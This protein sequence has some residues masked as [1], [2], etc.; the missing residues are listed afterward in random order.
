MHCEIIIKTKLKSD[1]RVG[2]AS[3]IGL[4][5]SDPSNLNSRRFHFERQRLIVFIFKGFPLPIED[6]LPILPVLTSQG[7]M[8]T[9]EDH[10][11]EAKIY[12]KVLVMVVMETD[13]RL[14]WPH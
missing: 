7:V 1:L 12:V 13:W 5:S 14:P 6:I 4:T 2:G 10:C 3:V 8:E 11:V 9:V